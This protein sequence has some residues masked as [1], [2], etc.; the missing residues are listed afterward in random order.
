MSI[1]MGGS[2][3]Q[4]GGGGSV[5]MGGNE[6][7]QNENMQKMGSKRGLGSGLIVQKFDSASPSF[8][9]APHTQ[10][11]SGSQKEG[12]NEGKS[13]I[14]A[15]FSTSFD[16]RDNIVSKAVKNVVDMFNAEKQV[17]EKSRLFT[18]QVI[19]LL[20]NPFVN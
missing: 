7:M 3:G 5:G 13:G 15:S 12:K 16:R 20:S 8:T 4:G 1:N 19:Y 9:L 18:D 6:Q 14:T 2:M 10:N 17:G 11:L